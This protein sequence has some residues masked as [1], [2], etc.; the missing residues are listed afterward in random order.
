MGIIAQEM[1]N[2]FPDTIGTFN[3]KLNEDDEE[4]TELLGYDGHEIT[5]ALIN[6][7]KE[8]NDKIT[9]LET[10]IKTLLNQ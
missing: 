2:I 6:A 4:E 5:F 9:D 1:I 8:L 10:Q 7:V 3:A